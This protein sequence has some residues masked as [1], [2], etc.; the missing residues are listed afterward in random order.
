M[1]DLIQLHGVITEACCRSCFFLSRY[2]CT[3][4]LAIFTVH[5]VYFTICFYHGKTTDVQCLCKVEAALLFVSALAGFPFTVFQIIDFGSS[6]NLRYG[7]PQ[8]GKRFKEPRY[9]NQHMVIHQEP[10]LDCTSCGRRFRWRTKPQGR[11]PQRRHARGASCDADAASGRRTKPVVMSKT[12][13]IQC[14]CTA[15]WLRN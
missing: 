15:A 4:N 5:I 10:H 3:G 7:C 11:L 9:V 2:D 13:R 8:C 12:C 1:I 6:G 14:R